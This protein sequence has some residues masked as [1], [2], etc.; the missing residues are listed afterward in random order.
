MEAELESR[1]EDFSSKDFRTVLGSFATGVTVVTTRSPGPAY[2]MTANAFS[3]VSLE[4]PL[5]LVCAKSGT[6]GSGWIQENG[7]FAVNILAEDQEDVSNY[8]ASKERPRDS[9][10]FEHIPYRKL[11]SGSP[12]LDGVA[13]Y[14]DCALAAS[15]DAGDH[16]I[17]IGEVLALGHDPD[18]SPLLFHGGGYCRLKGSD[19]SGSG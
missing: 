14:L 9:V 2:G 5:V 6:D 7:V 19:P 4:P 18:A 12:I 15:H 13:A 11:V 17:L 8:F 10:A 16:V 1:R 3:S